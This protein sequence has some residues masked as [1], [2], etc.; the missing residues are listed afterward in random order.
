MS[1]LVRLRQII[2][3]VTKNLFR[4]SS[5][6]NRK[7]RHSRW[8]DTTIVSD[9]IWQDSRGKQSVTASERLFRNFSCVKRVKSDSFREF[10]PMESP[11]EMFRPAY[12]TDFSDA[13]CPMTANTQM[14]IGFVSRKPGTPRHYG[15]PA[16]LSA[17]V[18]NP[19]VAV[20]GKNQPGLA[21]W[22]HPL[23]CGAVSN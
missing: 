22:G 21:F 2:G 7:Q 3:V 10:Y 9:I 4:Q 14:C 12:P 8:R 11:S 19:M 18:P 20:T 6:D 17:T 23:P 16:N 15:D 13:R 5:I 1:P